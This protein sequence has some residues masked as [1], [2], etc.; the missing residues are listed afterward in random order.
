MIVV[1]NFKRMHLVRSAALILPAAL[2]PCML[3]GVAV[4]P[5]MGVAQAKQEFHR[6][7]ELVNYCEGRREGLVEFGS[8]ERLD[9]ID[10]LADEL[11]GLIPE[12]PTLAMVYGKIRVAG[13]ARHLTLQ[14]IQFREREDLGLIID[15]ETVGMQQVVINGTGGLN[16]IAGLIDELKGR[17]LP[18]VPLAFNFARDKPEDDEF[19]F[20]LRLGVFHYMSASTDEAE[21]DSSD[22]E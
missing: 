14:T 18:A 15:E 8:I 22:T 11:H 1:H 21:D 20:E 19:R 9:T 10:S 5:A 13:D 12:Q 17:C 4:K 6:L 7:Q 16:N 3:V 2:L